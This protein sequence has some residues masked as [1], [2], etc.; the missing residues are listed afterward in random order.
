MEVAS[1]WHMAPSLLNNH[2][3]AALG[4]CLSGLE[5]AL[6]IQQVQLRIPVTYIILATAISTSHHKRQIHIFRANS[7]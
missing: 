5:A 1:L 7:T 6:L 3:K 2:K 4:G